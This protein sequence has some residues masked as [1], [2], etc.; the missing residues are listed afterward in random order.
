M[1][2]QGVGIQFGPDVTARFLERNGL[3]YVIRS[4]EV[5]ADGYEVC[6]DGK[7]ITV[8]SAPNY[9]DTM[10]NQGAFITL[11]GSDM[12]PQF[13]TYQAVV[14][15]SCNRSHKL[16]STVIKP[17]LKIFVTAKSLLMLKLTFYV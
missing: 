1:L 6:H 14:S 15:F 13:T 12:K 9:C 11:N 8:F 2:S 17:C 5:K 7:C 10:G 16:V 3:D 4:H